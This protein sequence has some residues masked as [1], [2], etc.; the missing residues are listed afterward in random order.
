MSRLPPTTKGRQVIKVNAMSQ[1]ALIKLLLDGTRSCRELAEETGLHYVTVLQYTR[2]LHKAKAVHIAEW[3][4]DARGRDMIKI[5]K[6]GKGADTKRYR[7][8]DT[9]KSKRYRE[10]QK[11]REAQTALTLREE[12]TC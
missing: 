10:S 1:A 5:Y 9:I 3:H 4:P 2:E 7:I 12:T 6:I 11:L 8:P